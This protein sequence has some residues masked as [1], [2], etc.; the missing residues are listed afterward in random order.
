MTTTYKELE[1]ALGDFVEE[2]FPTWR[3]KY[4]YDNAPELQTPYLVIDVRKMQAIGREYTS[5]GLSIDDNNKSYTTTTQNYEVLVRFEF[6]GKY[7]VNLE[8]AEMAQQL[9]FQLRTQ[10]GYEAQSRHALSL[11]SFIPVRRL[12]V[13]RE[14][15]TYMYYQLDVHFGYALTETVEQDY[16]VD[17]GIHGVY[18]DAGREPDHIIETSIEIH[19]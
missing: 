10:N 3:I 19:P 18:H 13:K 5:S 12:S 9:E 15:D 8:L 14:T 2:L 11:M 7:D 6:V 17:L 4:A 16:I 1:D